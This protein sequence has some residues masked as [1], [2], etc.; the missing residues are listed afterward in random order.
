MANKLQADG[1]T[2]QLDVAR[3]GRVEKFPMDFGKADRL[4]VFGDYQF[5]TPAPLYLYGGL[6]D[7]VWVQFMQETNRVLHLMF[8][9]FEY[10]IFRGL[11]APNGDSDWN[12]VLWAVTRDE[13]ETLESYLLSLVFMDQPN[14]RVH[15]I[16]AQD[17]LITDPLFVDKRK[18]SD[19]NAPP[20]SVVAL[21]VNG[22]TRCIGFDP[23][24]QAP[25]LPRL[26]S[27]PP[28]EKIVKFADTLFSGLDN[29]Q[30]AT[31]DME[32]HNED[33]P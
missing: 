5:F 2:Y 17:L 9:R 28:Q 32:T 11:E 6:T 18:L 13:F 16:G 23:N 4:S 15:K 20:L 10:S 30:Q 31:A 21:G 27:F 1:K 26:Q 8:H 24:T 12:K 22:N 33:Q 29:T 19:P 25:V 3:E 14:R 7:H